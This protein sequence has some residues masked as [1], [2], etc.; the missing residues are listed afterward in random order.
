[1]PAKRRQRSCLCREMLVEPP[2]EA[3]EQAD[4]LFAERRQRGETAQLMSGSCRP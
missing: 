4:V 1:M 3:G 2:E